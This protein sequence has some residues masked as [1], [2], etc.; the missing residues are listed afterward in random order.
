MFGQ[1]VRLARHS[2]VYGVGGLVSRILAVLFLPLYTRYLTPRDYGEIETLVALSA[3][4]VT[5]LRMGIP[6]AFFRFYFD[7]A[8]GRDRL[9]LIRTSFWFTMGVATAA[10]VAGLLASDAIAHWLFGANGSEA[11]VGAACVGLWTQMNYEQLT[12]LFRVEQR[13][14]GFV[15]ASLGNVLIT[16]AAT[17]FFVVVLRAGA[18]GVLVGN[19]LGTLAVYLV[20][21]VRRRTQLGLEFD[22][23]LLRAMNRFG[24]PLVPAALALWVV[25]F[26][27]R[28]FLIKLAGA[29]EVGLYSIGVRMSSA[30]LLLLIA[31]STAW[32]AFAYSLD[33]D[34][35]ARRT[36]GFVLTYLLFLCCW[37]SLALGLL[38]PWLVRLLTTPPFYS[39]ARVVAPLAFS[40]AAYA[41]Y[42]VVVVGVGRAGRTGFNWVVAGAAAV[43]NTALNVALIPRYGMIG[44]AVA[45]LAAY[46]ALFAGMAWHAQR[47]YPVPYQWNRVL[48]LFGS[49]AALT[50]LGMTLQLP[51]LAALAVILTYPVVLALAGFF[52]PS[53][54]T[55]LLRLVYHLSP[56]R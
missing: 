34:R 31:F 8:D 7:L 11:L 27:D 1:L 26:A 28:F 16:V 41:G 47:I 32:P 42:T 55:R 54:R 35:E 46:A 48:V 20:L 21:L 45:T 17:L 29:R 5:V 15:L 13:S 14:V 52:V 12:A 37:L 38:S 33:D 30:I 2:A 3:V 24:L 9:R 44:A 49:A 40:L 4:L 56:L 53:E 43:V 6:S 10:L 50:V 23:S 36:Y 19:F 25:N 39:S 22:G 51:L 18:T